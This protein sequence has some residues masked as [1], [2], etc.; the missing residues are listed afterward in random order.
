VL[1]RQ[2]GGPANGG[3]ARRRSWPA[4]GA[5]AAG[6][7]D[8]QMR[9]TVGAVT[10]A[11]GTDIGRSARWL[12]LFC[13]LLGLAMMHTLGHLGMPMDAHLQT[14]AQA[15]AHVAAQAE[16]PGLVITGL[17]PAELMH[18]AIPAPCPDGHCD[19]MPAHG[20]CVRGNC[21]SRSSAGSRWYC[22]WEGSFSDMHLP[23]P[24]VNAMVSVSAGS[25]EGR[26][27]FEQ[28]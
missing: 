1:A 2:S 28:D 14:A 10:R 16:T 13:T 23:T 22:C 15:E 25:A 6:R 7:V 19:D 9:A 8:A 4:T 5:Q 24:D 26:R 3:D 18:E 27:I 21:A 17:G 11:Q 12:L 20:G